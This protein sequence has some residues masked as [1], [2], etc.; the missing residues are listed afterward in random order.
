MVHSLVRSF[1]RRIAPLA[2]G[3]TTLGAAAVSSPAAAAAVTFHPTVS[4][5]QFIA[6]SETPPTQAQ[7]SSVNRRCFNPTAEE[8]SYNLGPLYAQ[9]LMGQ[10]Q[11]IVIVDSFGSETMRHDLHVFNNAFGLPHMCGEENYVCQPGD[12]SFSELQQGRTNTN[13]IPSSNSTGQETHSLWALE[14]ALD[15]E[16]SHSMAPKANILLVTTPTAET[17]GVQGFPDFFKAEDYVIQH[18]LGSVITQS[19]ASAEEAF[20]STQ[21]LLNLRYA[22]QDAQAN[23]VTVF[24]SSGDGGTA[25]VIKTPVKSPTAIPFPSVEWP[26]SDPLVTGVGGTYECTNPNTGSLSADPTFPPVQ[27]QNNPTQREV[28]WIGAGGGYSHVFAKPSFQN[29]LPAGSTAIGAARGVPDIALQASSRTGMLVYI[30]NPGY[31]GI[32]CP[33]GQLCSSGWYVVG[34]TS[35]S[36]PQWAG[37]IAIANQLNHRDHPN[38]ANLGYINPALYAIASNPAKYAADFFDVTTG[39]NQADPTIPGYNAT[40]GWDPVTGLGTPNAANLIP[41][42]VTAVSG[43]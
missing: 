27:C 10:G 14:V 21:S 15:V 5:I 41:D 11:T 1:A 31:S 19:F 12:P 24:G 35:S 43:P 40:P 23:H 4:D 32:V 38:S 9:G 2:I 37:L 20:N 17:L 25:N 22:F 29:S 8:N 34:G 39:N 7:C 16:W 26:A 18:H 30:T 42:L 36:S 6:A 3:A 13:P 33:G 28:G